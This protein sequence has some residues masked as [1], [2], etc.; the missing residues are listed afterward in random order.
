[1]IDNN[2]NMHPLLDKEKQKQ[3]KAYEKKKRITGLVSTVVSLLFALTFYFSG[4][5][6]WLAFYHEEWKFIWVLTF[7]LFVFMIMYFIVEFP[8]NYYS[9]FVLEHAWGFSNQKFTQWMVEQGKSLAVSFILTAILLGGFIWVMTVF[10]RYWW[11]MAGLLTSFFSVVMATL[12]PV[13]ILPIFNTYTPIEDKE[14]KKSLE[15]I[16]SK[17]GLKSRGFFR[18]DMSRQTKKENAFLAGMGKTRRVVLGDNL[19][20]K[21]S[22]QEIASIMA[23]EVGHYKYNHIWKFILIGTAQY[24]IVFF[25]THEILQW[26]VPAFPGGLR[27]NLAI[28]PIIAVL[29]GFFSTLFFGPLIHALSRHFERQ[30]DRYAVKNIP[31]RKAFVTAMAGL[32]NRNLANAYPNRWIKF[33]YYSHP[34][35]GE[36]LET[37]EKNL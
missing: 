33:F 4:L 5:S 32:A 24:L 30:A 8:V 3:A 18:E 34:P 13:V 1:V 19:L 12:L 20:K 6:R 14:L 22:R 2:I 17:E 29:A 21:M 9:G 28:F 31:D 15:D 25:V 16:L 26:L 27:M 10:P 23:H 35:V 11:L 36:R 37:A 7:Y